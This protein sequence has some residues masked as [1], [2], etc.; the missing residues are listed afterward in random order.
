MTAKKAKPSKPAQKQGQNGLQKKQ[1]KE[2][3]VKKKDFNEGLD[4]RFGADGSGDPSSSAGASYIKGKNIENQN[5]REEMS[6]MTGIPEGKDF[7]D[8]SF[9]VTENSEQATL[10]ASSKN[11]AIVMK[12]FKE[13]QRQN[14]HLKRQTELQ[15]FI[16]QDLKNKHLDK[17]LDPSARVCLESIKRN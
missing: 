9:K 3:K 1:K 5:I 14:Q 10:S 16:L 8:L 2:R 12:I 4:Q 7:D 17:H 13:T 11:M 6:D 15:S